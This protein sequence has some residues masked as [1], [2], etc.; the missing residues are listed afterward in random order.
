MTKPKSRRTAMLTLPSISSELP[1]PDEIKGLV[2]PDTKR[3]RLGSCEIL[4]SHSDAGWHLSISCA[5][6]YPSWDEIAKAR[7][8]L[9]PDEALMV[10]I[11]PSLEQYVNLHPYTFHLWEIKLRNVQGTTGEAETKPAV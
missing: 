3:Y 6:R 2:E 10:M 11:L 7:Y 8:D 4:L 9:I 1:V 5:N